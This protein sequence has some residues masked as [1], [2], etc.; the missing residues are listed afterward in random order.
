MS[1]PVLT[2]D[3]G[4]SSVKAALFDRDGQRPGT[5]V[6]MPHDDVSALRRLI[7]RHRPGHAV[8]SAVCEVPALDRLPALSGLP[9]LRLGPDTPVPIVIDYDTPRTLGPD[10]VAAAVGAWDWARQSGHSGDLLV[11][12]AGTAATIDLVTADGHFAGGNIAA[13][14]ALRLRALH[15]HTGRLPLL[16]RDDTAGALP[17]LGRDTRSALACGAAR[18]L[19]AEVEGTARHIGRAVT[20]RLP[21]VVLTGGDGPL[22]ARLVT[23]PA[24]A[25][26]HLTLQGLYKIYQYN[27]TTE[28]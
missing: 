5:A 16:E 23:L 28:Q 12:D 3:C 8:L 18:G 20:G 1:H 13:G 21:L 15:E 19:A 24:V 2:I 22:L 26:P 25:L 27:S 14:I 17:P 9:M 10:R 11:V 6:A 7:E 4:N